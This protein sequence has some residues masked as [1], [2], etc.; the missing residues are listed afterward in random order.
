MGDS[1]CG[2]L[3]IIEN[4]LTHT[5]S[6]IPIYNYDILFS[7]FVVLI[8]GNYLWSNLLMSGY[9]WVIINMHH[10]TCVCVLLNLV[11]NQKEMKLEKICY[12]D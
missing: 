7:S 10:Y 1:S 12:D 6:T 3:V 2:S 11:G 4:T 5:C 9:E 8:F